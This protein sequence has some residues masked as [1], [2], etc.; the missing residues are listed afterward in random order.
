M[1]T[2]RRVREIEQILREDPRSYWSSPDLQRELR[3]LL[4]NLHGGE[5]DAQ[6]SENG[7]TFDI[8]A[9]DAPPIVLATK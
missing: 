7:E 4:A 1:K 9:N 5:D 2:S 8:G 6:P 3:E